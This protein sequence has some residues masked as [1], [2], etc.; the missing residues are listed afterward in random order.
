MGGGSSEVW[1]VEASENSKRGIVWEV[2]VKKLIGY[3]ILNGGGGSP[4]EEESGSGKGLSLV[5]RWH[6]RMKEHGADGVVCG[7]K[8]AFSLAILRRGIRTREVERNAIASEEGCGS[9]V[10]ELGP[11]ISLE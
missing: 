8:H 1:I 7:A 4:I 6:G 3:M 5:G 10:N 9:M 11:I 2:F